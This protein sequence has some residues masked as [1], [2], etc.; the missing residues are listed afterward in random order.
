MRTTDLG[1]ANSRFA[2]IDRN[3]NDMAKVQREV[4][5]GRRIHRSSDQP[6]DSTRV[7]RHDLR[8]QRVKQ[9]DRNA[10][11][12][13][14]WLGGA[15]QALQAGA[16]SLG[17]AKALAV[18]AG[19]DTLGVVENRALAD[20]I[21]AIADGLLTVAN[22]KVSGRAVF[23]GTADTPNAYDATGSYLGDGG[24]VTRTIDT[25]E[26]VEVGSRGPDVFGLS[27]PADPINGNVFEVLWAL[28]DAVEAG[29]NAAVRTGIEAVDTA[30]AR[31]GTA[32]GR[33]GALSQQIDAATTRHS[34]ERVATDA[35]ISQLRDV[36]IADAVIRLR[37]A[38]AS[39]E[40]TLSATSRALSRSLLDFLR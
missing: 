34:S 40:A 32:Q 27:N 25:T 15:D 24:T 16:I 1:M 39:Y 30:T 26:S 37:S 3:R 5:T 21:R 20:D 35:H 36:D 13:R 14:L 22:T 17:R 7:L 9:F 23:A 31:V 2:W 28:A 8:L 19:N 29:D 33:V 38:E 10:D 6:A 11:N 12:A 4:A 18:Q